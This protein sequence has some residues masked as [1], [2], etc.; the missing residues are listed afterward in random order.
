MRLA[1]FSPMPPVRSGIAVDSAELV[2]AL[3]GE[4][5]ID[6][7]VDE[8][9][10]RL[11][12]GARSAHDF[13]WRH[14]QRPYDLTV[15]QLG[16]SSHHDYLWP[17]LFRYPG[18][19]V[20]HDA[21]LHHARAAA[22]L[23]SGRPDDYRREFAANHPDAPLDAAELAVRG[24]DS[25][26]YYLWPMTRLVLTASRL[27][28]VHSAEIAAELRADLPEAA[29]EVIRL[30]HGVL[31]TTERENRAKVE[32]RARFGLAPDTLLFGCFGGVT[33]D[34]RITQVLNA[35]AGILPDAPTAHLLIAGGAAGCYDVHGEIERRGVADRVTV[36]GYLAS[37]EELT[38]CIAAADVTLNLRW[39]TAREISGPWLR[40]LAA[41][42]PTVIVDLRQTVGVPSLDPRS[43]AIH[44]A[45]PAVCVALDILDEEHSLGLAMSRLARDARLRASLGRAAREYWLR[46]HTVEGMIEDYRRAIARAAARATPQVR[47]PA[48]LRDEGA[49]LL[50]ELAAPFGAAVSERIREI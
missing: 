35:F 27:S 6:V 14:R 19:A 23:R 17:Y 13:V 50:R 7:F 49:S 3:H 30:G 31:V 15:Y 37:D 39:P 10:A 2:R 26:L 48:H 9:V 43:W 42:K 38:D 28:A 36:T 47:L 33:P 11:A 1:W 44:D 8:P 21:H 40:C 25:I 18:L 41:G 22:L 34:K 45:G 5:E 46:E 29:I 20:L 16:N 32:I 12:P 24:Y 4:H